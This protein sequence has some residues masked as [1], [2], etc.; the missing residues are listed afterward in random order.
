MVSI[1]ADQCSCTNGRIYGLSTICFR[2]TVQLLLLCM[3]YT[4]YLS[5]SIPLI[6]D[7]LPKRSSSLLILDEW[8]L[9]DDALS[10]PRSLGSSLFLWCVTRAWLDDDVT[11]HIQILTHGAWEWSY[12]PLHQCWLHIITYYFFSK[13]PAHLPL[14]L[15]RLLLT[16]FLQQFIHCMMKKSS[17]SQ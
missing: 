10:V 14:K 5:G 1:Q 17:S 2:P 4:E 9:M 12:A 7:G 11:E 16:L 3:V 8:C 6:A 15:D 13:V